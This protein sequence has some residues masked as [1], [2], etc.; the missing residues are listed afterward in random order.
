M[1]VIAIAT[2]PD[3]ILTRRSINILNQERLPF[4]LKQSSASPI[5]RISSFGVTR[6][7]RSIFLFA[8]TAF[9]FLDE[10]LS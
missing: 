3:R 10:I 5:L 6:C 2:C 8:F 9:R 7:R 4:F 1:T